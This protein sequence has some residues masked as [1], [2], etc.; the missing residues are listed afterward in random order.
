M[1]NTSSRTK[2]I[3]FRVPVDVSEVLERRAN[4]NGIKV[5]EYVKQFLTKDVRRKR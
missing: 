1:P 4:R 2:P 3:A 5:S